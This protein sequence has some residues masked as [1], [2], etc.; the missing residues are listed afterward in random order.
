MDLQLEYMGHWQKDEKISEAVMKRKILLDLDTGAKSIPSLQLLAKRLQS[1]LQ[2]K[3][4]NVEKQRLGSISV[5]S[6]LRTGR[7]MDEPAQ[8]APGNTARFWRTLLGEV[9]A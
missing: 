8:M 1:F 7:F 6:P 2:N 9:K 4:S 5:A 3:D